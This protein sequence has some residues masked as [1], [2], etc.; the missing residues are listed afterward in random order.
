MCWIPGTKLV[1][2]TYIPDR[3][4]VVCIVRA[5]T[6][7]PIQPRQ[8]LNLLSRCEIEEHAGGTNRHWV[9]SHLLVVSPVLVVQYVA[10]LQASLD[11]SEVGLNRLFTIIGDA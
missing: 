5:L 2:V 4:I 8:I 10:Y 7:N 11:F 9:L 3:V 6:V 1:N